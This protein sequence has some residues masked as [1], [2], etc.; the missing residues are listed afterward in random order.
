MGL[1]LVTDDTVEITPSLLDI[2]GKLRQMAD[3]M[4][5]DPDKCPDTLLWVGRFDNSAVS[6]GMLGSY[7]DK[8]GV[9]GLLTLAQRKFNDGEGD[10]VHV[11]SSS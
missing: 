1:K 7:M 2:P 8:F 5:A 9:V 10:A 6:L 11:G 4:E 3:E